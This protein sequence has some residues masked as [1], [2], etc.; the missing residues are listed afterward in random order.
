[1]F[2]NK[3][4]WGNKKKGKSWAVTVKKFA[5]P[6]EREN[7]SKCNRCTGVF[8]ITRS[9]R[10]RNRTGSLFFSRM[11]CISLVSIKFDALNIKLRPEAEKEDVVGSSNNT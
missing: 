10:E 2:Y 9:S 5:M 11:T 1:M 7:L 6:K 8:G 3:G 4:S